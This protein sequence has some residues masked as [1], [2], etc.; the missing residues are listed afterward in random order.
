LFQLIA[1]P[2]AV[3]PLLS[4]HMLPVLPKSSET[5]AILLLVSGE[6]EHLW[7]R[8]E[9]VV[10]KVRATSKKRPA[11]RSLGDV[12]DKTAHSPKLKLQAVR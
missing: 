9:N 7:I 3:T 6:I 1:G 5:R 12:V 4:P 8:I 11:N 2:L 10:V